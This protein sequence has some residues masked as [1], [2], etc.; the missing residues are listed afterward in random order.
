MRNWI[1]ER[2][3]SLPAIAVAR[4]SAFSPGPSD[5]ILTGQCKDNNMAFTHAMC[6]VPERNTKLLQWAVRMLAICS[7]WTCFY[8]IR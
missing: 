8:L 2:I 7:K 4:V 6:C 5:P 1:R 3:I